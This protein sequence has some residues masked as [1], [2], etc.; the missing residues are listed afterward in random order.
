MKEGVPMIRYIWNHLEEIFLIPTLAFSV[1][2]IF[3]QVIMRYVF[4]SSLAWSEELGRYLFVWQIWMGASFAARNKT[5]LRITI[6][7]DKMSSASQKTLELV[8][9]IVWMAFGLFV[10]Y[11]G[12]G[13]VMKMARFNQISPAMQIPMMYV[14]MAVPLGCGL[15]V[16]RLLENTIKDFLCKA[17]VPAEITVPGPSVA[18]E[19][20]DGG[21]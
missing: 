3:M 9:T 15:M 6:V 1:A 5:H 7:K 17:P 11:Q 16:V 19:D 8:V 13:L 14:H 4:G 18:R 10:V 20:N 2:L 21:R 12:I